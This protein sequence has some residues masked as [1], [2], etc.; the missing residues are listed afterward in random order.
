M[1]TEPLFAVP[2][3]TSLPFESLLGWVFLALTGIFVLHAIVVIYHWYTFGSERRISTLSSIIYVSV[4]VCILAAM[5][6]V[7]LLR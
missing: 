1:P 2:T 7:L 4:G 3:I 5:G 6:I